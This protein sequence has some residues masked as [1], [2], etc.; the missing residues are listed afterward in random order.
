MQ[1]VLDNM[2]RGRPLP[3]TTK[4]I[5]TD[6]D[7]IEYTKKHSKPVIIHGINI[8][9][10]DSP[11]FSVFRGGEEAM[12][13]YKD[14][15]PR[16]YGTKFSACSYTVGL[17]PDGADIG[18]LHRYII[19]SNGTMQTKLGADVKKRI[20]IPLYLNNIIPMYK[21]IR[22][23]G[24]PDS[25]EL[26]S[27]LKLAYGYLEYS[28]KLTLR[29]IMFGYPE[30]I[31][32]SVCLNFTKDQ[33]THDV[34]GGKLISVGRWSDWDSDQR[35][36]S[37]FKD[38]A[39]GLASRGCS[40]LM[41]GLIYYAGDTITPIG[42]A[43]KTN[44]LNYGSELVILDSLNIPIYKDSMYLD[45]TSS[46]CIDV[47]IDKWKGENVIGRGTTYGHLPMRMWATFGID[48]NGTHRKFEAYVTA[49][50][51]RKFKKGLDLEASRKIKH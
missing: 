22:E 32:N 49:Q 9:G 48:N 25:C 44:N 45:R 34:N 38:F 40:Y 30:D 26:I 4:D 12:I 39:Y 51:A 16:F 29:E 50:D 17:N 43:L 46:K 41:A 5:S 33:L 6:L 21:L 3:R 10:L 37:M 27:S 11:S 14:P 36:T 8:I 31:V 20:Y 19:P 18:V 35:M 1:R 13:I 47:A 2:I 15:K 42:V 24:Y 28:D 7:L 23:S